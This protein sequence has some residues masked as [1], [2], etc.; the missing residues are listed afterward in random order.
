MLEIASITGVAP[1][2]IREIAALVSEPNT[3]LVAW[4][5]QESR[6][7]RAPD[8]LKALATL[9]VLVGKLG[10]SGSGLALMTSQANASGAR[11]AGC[12]SH[13]LPGGVSP[14]HA[15]A[16]REVAAV[17]KTD[18]LPLFIKS[19]T[20][21]RRKLEK[22]DMRAAFVFGE[23][24]AVAPEYNA[25]FN[26]LEFLVVADLYLTDTAQMANVFLPLSHYLEGSGHITNWSGLRQM[27]HPIG[28]PANGMTTY[29][30]VARMNELAGHTISASNQTEL[31][32]ELEYLCG[33]VRKSQNGRLFPTSDGK[34]HLSS[35]AIH[36]GVTSASAPHVLEID[37]RMADRMKNIRA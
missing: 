23:N 7:D 31:G 6:I 13:V 27:T 10:V 5:N 34:A 26:N 19:G 1:E 22:S 24:P 3:K 14:E 2:K 11:L 9:L 30:L 12:D 25:L 33:Q 32:A 36:A 35:W 16:F 18:L 17:W 29:D 20:S 37:G 21:L 15:D 8:D 4:Y 28:A